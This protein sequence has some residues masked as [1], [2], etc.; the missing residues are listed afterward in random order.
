MKKILF[1]LFVVCMVFASCSQD[2]A[3][4]ATFFINYDA[5][6]ENP[7]GKIEYMSKPQTYVRDKYSITALSCLY[8]NGDYV[9]DSWNTKA[10]GSG[11]R[12][13]PGDPLSPSSNITLYAQ[14]V[15]Y[16]SIIVFEANGGTGTMGSIDI[17]SGLRLPKCTFTREGYDFLGWNTKHDYNGT[18]YCDE[19][20][21]SFEK[22]TVLYAQWAVKDY[23]DLDESG[24]LVRGSAYNTDN[25]KLGMPLPKYLNGQVVKGTFSAEN[26]SDGLFYNL[27][28]LHYVS[29]PDSYEEIGSYTFMG[30][31]IYGVT[32]PE[33]CRKICECAFIRT[34]SLERIEIL[35]TDLEIGPYA[36]QSAAL[37]EVDLKNVKKIDIYAFSN[38]PS[39]TSAL[40]PD[41]EELGY[42]AFWKTGLR[43]I[44]IP[45]TVEVVSENAFRQCD[46][47]ESVVLNEGIKEIGEASFLRCTAI[48]TL[49]IP[50]SCL[51][52]GDYAFQFDTIEDLDLG[53]G[54]RTIGKYAFS[55]NTLISEVTV[56]VSVQSFGEGAFWDDTELA[57][58][59]YEGTT[60]Q[61]RAIEQGKHW[62]LNTQI[63]EVHLV[64]AKTLKL[65]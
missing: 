53:N 28:K 1:I 9:F 57:T 3:V 6:C 50:D 55:K 27:R 21:V 52:V 39:L 15:E 47:L 18:P 40:I 60:E 41:L 51:V 5:N 29:I 62:V 30:C 26:E 63:T 33:S 22:R 64:A 36:F 45:G 13:M 35:A 37:K 38:N 48:R 4:N 17:E 25:V 44:D 20:V 11:T 54:V 58:M 14:W 56:P 10:D 19:Q 7:G 46:A 49:R 34:S 65:Y 32:I 61:W 59:Y 2:E 8:E 31:G 43:E 24:M 16:K 12:V 42:A 23:F